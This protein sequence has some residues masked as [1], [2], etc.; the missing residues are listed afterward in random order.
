MI[1]IMLGVVRGPCH[2][3]WSAK[4]FYNWYRRD[5]GKRSNTWIK[6]RLQEAASMARRL[7]GESAGSEEKDLHGRA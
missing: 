1:H 6:C 3:G 4:H 2:E 7:G 5:G